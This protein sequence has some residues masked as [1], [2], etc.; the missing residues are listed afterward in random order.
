MYEIIFSVLLFIVGSLLIFVPKFTG[1]YIKNP[2]WSKENLE[3]TPIIGGIGF[4]CIG[5]LILLDYFNII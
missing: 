2:I 4:Y 1:T 3:K 5:I